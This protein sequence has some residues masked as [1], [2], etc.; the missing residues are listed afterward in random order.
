[1]HIIDYENT[2]I[3][4]GDIKYHTPDGAAFIPY[5]IDGYT[6]SVL[7]IAGTLSMTNDLSNYSIDR[8][9]LPS[10]IEQIGHHYLQDNMQFKIFFCNK[11]IDLFDLNQSLWLSE[12]ITIYVPSEY[13]DGYVEINQYKQFCKANVCYYFNIDEDDYYYVDYYEEE[14]LIEFIP[15]SPTREGYT[16]D[17]WYK[18]P[19]FVNK[20]NFVN[21]LSTI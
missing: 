8:L 13:Y 1:M 16:F 19:D 14:G 9:Y 5:N 2:K 18:E 21:I 15:P 10:T 7:G 17:G 4:I 12:T 11:P 3:A 20:W 6:V